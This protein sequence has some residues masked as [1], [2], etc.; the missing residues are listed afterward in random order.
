MT[1]KTFFKYFLTW[2]H[3]HIEKKAYCLYIW[4]PT[5]NIKN[6]RKKNC[7]RLLRFFE[8]TKFLIDFLYFS[9]MQGMGKGSFAFF[10][11]VTFVNS[12][13]M[14]LKIF[15][16]HK[17]WKSVFFPRVKNR[18]FGFWRFLSKS[19]FRHTFVQQKILWWKLVILPNVRSTVALEHSPFT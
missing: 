14:Q 5:W 15:K 11:V 7:F 9:L 1:K 2:T 17:K 19:C 13:F 4:C 3:Q 6:Y 8:N 16:W 18:R 12:I 10:W